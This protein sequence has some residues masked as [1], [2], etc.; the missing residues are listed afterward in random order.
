[1]RVTSIALT[2]A[3]LVPVGCRGTPHPWDSREVARSW[4]EPV[5]VETVSG[6]SP[7]LARLSLGGRR[8]PFARALSLL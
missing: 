3:A 4:S 6:D 2:I 1:M 5:E 7:R 8:E